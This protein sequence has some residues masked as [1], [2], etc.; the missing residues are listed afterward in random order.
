MSVNGVDRRIPSPAMNRNQKKK[1][2]CMRGLQIGYGL[3]WL[4]ALCGVATDQAAAVGFRGTHAVV[5]HE[6]AW[7]GT[8]ESDQQQWIELYNPQ[9]QPVS[10]AGW[11]LRCRTRDF[12]LP[13][14]G[15]IPPQ[16][17]FLIVHESHPVL[18]GVRTDM[19]FSG[20]GFASGMRLLLEDQRGRIVD[21]VDRWYAGD[22]ETKATMQR[23]YPY[24]AG[25]T[26]GSW[27]T[28]RVRYD[29]GFGTPGFRDTTRPT[30]QH[31]HAVYNGP[32]AINVYFNQPARTEFALP[33]NEANHSVNME[34]RLV[35]RIRRA[36][37]TIDIT[38]YELNLPRLADALIERAAAGVRVR[39]V[40]DSKEP[41]ADDLERVERWEVARMYLEK[42]MRGADGRLG[43]DDDIVI[44][45]NAPIY[46]FDGDGERRR[47]GG[48]P[49]RLIGIPE[50][51]IMVGNSPRTGRL[52]V[53]GERREDGSYYRPG[54]QMHNK[55]VVI[56]GRWVWTASMNFTVTDLYGS[57]EAMAQG[58]LRGNSNNALEIHSPE[59]AAIYTGSFEEMWG[60]SGDM[61]DPARARFSGRKEGRDEPFR[62]SV[63]DR[64][65]AVYFSPGFDVIPAL[66][67]FVEAEAKEKIYFAVFAWSDYELERAIKMKWEGDDGYQTG[68]QT[69]FELRGVIEFWDDWWSAAINMTGRIPDQS[70]ELNPNIRW[71]HQPAVFEPQETR[72]LHHKYMIIDADTAHNPT[73]VTGSAN[74]SNNANNIND[75]NTLFI[76]CPLI[77]NQ[78]VQDFYGIF[79]RAG[80]SL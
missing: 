63:G 47:S 62:L 40:T 48:L 23:V 79:L 38:I 5:I 14:S 24:R 44:L 41:D 13:L 69:G 67:R 4:L 71:R 76:S 25:Y 2:S 32:D 28:S 55:F 19:T 20:P 52:L 42:L 36:T 54:A 65:L 34:E 39:V 53:E 66:T 16:D 21:S 9:A 35:Q 51:E 59:L 60:G 6:I 11:Q 10:L 7:M 15:V 22:A 26:R 73:V 74:W 61:P 30:G 31:L 17:S 68:E 50:T 43:T 1:I 56:D 49:T 80:G 8:T 37:E 70:S 12:V 29:S 57:E 3:C 64:D 27:D 33:G 46:A 45:A 77:A 75:E 18:P 72:R 78:Y 58:A